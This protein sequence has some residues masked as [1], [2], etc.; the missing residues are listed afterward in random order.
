MFHPKLIIHISGRQSIF[1]ILGYLEFHCFT[2]SL[3]IN[4]NFSEINVLSDSSFAQ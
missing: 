1:T 3:F 4:T 2:V